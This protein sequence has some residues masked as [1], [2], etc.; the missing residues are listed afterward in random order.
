MD[1]GSKR[2]TVQSV[3]AALL[4]TASSCRQ[5]RQSCCHRGHAQAAR[6]GMERSDPSST[7]RCTP[8]YECPAGEIMTKA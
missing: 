4:R 1:G 6:R 5:A 2:G 3:A 7:V 8:T